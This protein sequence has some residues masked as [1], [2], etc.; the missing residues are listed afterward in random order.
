MRDSPEIFDG[1][2]TTFRI[3]T[4]NVHEIKD[5]NDEVAE[6]ILRASEG[7]IEMVKSKRITT[8]VMIYCNHTLATAKEIAEEHS[9]ERVVAHATRDPEVAQAFACFLD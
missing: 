4:D 3:I 8:S 1:G 2:A 5:L 6:T 9:T 7:T